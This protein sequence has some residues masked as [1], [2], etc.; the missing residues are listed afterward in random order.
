[1]A[2]GLGAIAISEALL[3]WWTRRPRTP[4]MKVAFIGLALRTVWMTAALLLGLGSGLVD[5]KVF[6]AA[7]LAAYLGAQV[8]E[9]FRYRRFVDNR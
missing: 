6:I 9:G 3:A 7:L 4:A 1:M 8:L 5:P 2:A